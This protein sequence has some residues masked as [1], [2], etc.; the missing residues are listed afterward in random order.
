MEH[1][2]PEASTPTIRHRVLG[3]G[4][5]STVVPWIVSDAV[6][7]YLARVERE[8]P[9]RISGFYIVGSAALG[10]FQ[11]GRSDVDFVAVVTQR[12]DPSELQR[13]RKV[14]R[15]LYLTALA[16][17]AAS[18]P[19]RWPLACNGVYVLRDDLGK[20]P[21]EIVP[22][23]SHVAGTFMAGRAFDVNPVTWRT[24]AKSA[25]AVQG[26]D[27][28]LLGIHDN[29]AEL[30]SWTLSNLNSYWYRWADDLNRPGLTA[31]KALLLRYVAW[32]VLGTSRMHFTIATGDIASKTQACDYALDVFAPKWRPLLEATRAYWHRTSRTTRYIS[33]LAR[34]HDTA[35]FVI[36]VIESA[37]AIA[38]A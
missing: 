12:L 20:S 5:V 28:A 15:R 16:K 8:I 3:C 4:N 17:A 29:D 25:I 26:I 23:A 9:G 38:D 31:V 18:P 32:G 14:Q 30:R 33:P 27:P 1:D 19:W 2:R 13:I 36:A 35:D 37:A 7:Q 22:V 24:L 11:P 21:L 34:R 10:D 6:D